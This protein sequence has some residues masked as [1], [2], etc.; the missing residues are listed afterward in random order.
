MGKE[1]YSATTQAE[2]NCL[3]SL[4]AEVREKEEFIERIRFVVNHEIRK[5]TSNILGLLQ[6]I[7]SCQEDL[8]CLKSI[9]TK[10]KSSADELDDSTRKINRLIDL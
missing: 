6:I 9:T 8:T 2:L 3:Q 4:N 10:L 7:D 1:S 5:S